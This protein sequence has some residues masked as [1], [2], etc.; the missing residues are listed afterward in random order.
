MPPHVDPRNGLVVSVKNRYVSNG[1]RMSPGRARYDYVPRNFHFVRSDA[2][3]PTLAY[4][5]VVGLHGG[6][7]A[8]QRGAAGASA[9]KMPDVAHEQADPAAGP[10]RFERGRS[11]RGGRRRSV[12]LL[13]EPVHLAT[14][15]FL[16][17]LHRVSVR[18]VRGGGTT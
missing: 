1:V 16:S 6:R 15:P 3:G 14:R 12:P 18:G 11:G 5:E 13:L 9:G 8:K 7:A 17:V 2:Q 4:A 10:P